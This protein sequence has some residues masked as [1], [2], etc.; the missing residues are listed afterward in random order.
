MSTRRPL[1][2]LSPLSPNIIDAFATHGQLSMDHQAQDMTHDAEGYTDR[3]SL[4]SLED[5]ADEFERMMIQNAR[6]E[7]RMRDAMQGK[8]QPF[9]KAR[10]HPRVSV[11]LENLE[12]L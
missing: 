4:T 3:M 12:R 10:T 1:Q 8:V 2:P 9:R 11:T 7:Q 5:G 6:D